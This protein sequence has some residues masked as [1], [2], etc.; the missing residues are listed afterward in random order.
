MNL[1]SVDS[2]V[3]GTNLGNLGRIAMKDMKT[4]EGCLSQVSSHFPPLMAIQHCSTLIYDSVSDLSRH[5][6]T[7]LT[8]N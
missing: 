8:Y 7:T 5:H 4:K 2:S 1:I 6:V 3:L